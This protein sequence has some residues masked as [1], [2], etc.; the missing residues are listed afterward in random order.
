MMF[1][2]RVLYQKGEATSSL[3]QQNTE[4]GG[5]EDEP[6]REDEHPSPEPVFVVLVHV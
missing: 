1:S 5:E 2:M 6:T 3:K 4:R